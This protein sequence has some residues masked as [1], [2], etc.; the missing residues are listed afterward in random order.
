MKQNKGLHDIQ[1]LR[2]PYPDY[3]MD[4]IESSLATDA[5]HR[6]HP[7]AKTMMWLDLNL[8]TASAA[9]EVV[10]EDCCDFSGEAVLSRL[11]L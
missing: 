7:H 8:N 3:F 4:G 10:C 2:V 1:T 6:P 11:C 5:I 9:T